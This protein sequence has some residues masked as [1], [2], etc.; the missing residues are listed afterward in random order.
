MGRKQLLNFLIFAAV[1]V[2]RA[3]LHPGEGQMRTPT[4]SAAIDVEHNIGLLSQELEKKLDGYVVCRRD[5]PP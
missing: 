4:V 1:T 5:T 2:G 3:V